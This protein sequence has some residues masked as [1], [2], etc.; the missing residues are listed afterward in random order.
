MAEKGQLDTP[1]TVVC[2][3]QPGNVGTSGEVGGEKII[4]TEDSVTSG[5]SGEIVTPF[6]TVFNKK[7]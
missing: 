3:K 1:F 6:N 2:G 4:S 7:G 5:G